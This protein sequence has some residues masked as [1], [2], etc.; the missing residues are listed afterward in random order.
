M[1]APSFSTLP[2]HQT[3]EGSR[4][5]SIFLKTDKTCLRQNMPDMLL[6]PALASFLAASQIAQ[7]LTPAIGSIRWF[8]ERHH[9]TAMPPD[10]SA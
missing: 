4:I 2:R 1:S 3:I 9:L 7:H 8:F 10:Q 5:E 6:Q